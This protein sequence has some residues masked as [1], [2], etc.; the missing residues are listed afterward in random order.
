M[1]KIIAA[2]I[3]LSLMA[4]P[5]CATDLGI[6]RGAL[7]ARLYDM[8]C[9]HLPDAVMRHADDVLDP[10]PVTVKLRE[11]ATVIRRFKIVGII[12][13]CDGIKAAFDAAESE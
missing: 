13:W 8:K 10:V 7:Q 11:T 6:V 4:S 3:G 1:R 9:H 2:C 12:T 5:A